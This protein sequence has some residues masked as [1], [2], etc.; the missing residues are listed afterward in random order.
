VTIEYEIEFENE[1]LVGQ[2]KRT[3]GF[4]DDATQLDERGLPMVPRSQMKGLLRERC[5]ELFADCA[6]LTRCFGGDFDPKAPTVSV[7]GGFRFSDARHGWLENCQ[8]KDAFGDVETAPRTRVKINEK[9]RRA[10]DDMLV[11]VQL[12]RPREALSGRIYEEPEHEA[13]PGRSRDLAALIVALRSL[14]EVGGWRRKGVGACRVTVSWDAEV[15][16]LLGVVAT[17][18]PGDQAQWRKLAADALG[19][20][21]VG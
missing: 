17:I 7:A 20:E 14:Q 5:R 15:S 18:P 3:A 8:D 16:E 12:G 11:T 19:K 21:A 13:V 9:K 4:L 1:L 6:L 10:A 2:G